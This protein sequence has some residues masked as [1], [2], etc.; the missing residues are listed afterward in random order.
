MGRALFA[1]GAL[2]VGCFVV[3]GLTV[4]LTREEDRVAVDSELAESITRAIATAEQRG[5]PVDLSRLAPFG[6]DRVLIVAE[7]TSRGAISAAIGS[8]FKGDLPY[9][10]ESGE[11]FVF[12]RGSALARFADY[13]GLGVF[14]GFERPIAAVERADARFDVRDLVVRPGG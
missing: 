1:V 9:D 6:W 5:Q 11:L 3:L 2:L 8:E 4:F 12:V 10:A 14:D 13:R 7:D